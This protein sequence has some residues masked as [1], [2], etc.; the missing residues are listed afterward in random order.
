[1]TLGESSSETLREGLLVR[2]WSI[3]YNLARY[4]GVEQPYKMIKSAED[5]KIHSLKEKVMYR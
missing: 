5:R 3:K 2:D 4:F 1:M